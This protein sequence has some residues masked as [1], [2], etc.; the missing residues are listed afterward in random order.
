M[1]TLLIVEPLCDGHRMGYVRWIAKAACGSGFQT[2]FATLDASKNHPLFQVMLE[3]CKSQLRIVTLAEDVRHTDRRTDI[4][5][6]ARRELHFYRLFGRLFR[7]SAGIQEPDV[8][9]VPYI[10]HC[11]QAMAL[12]GSPFN[13]TP[14][15]GI[16]LRPFSHFSRMGLHGP[17][18][19]MILK[20][21]EKT[22]L[23]LMT[24]RNLRTLFTI[25][26]VFNE[27]MLAHHPA[28]AR[29]LQLL[30]DPAE[31]VGAT[32]KEGA[33]QAFGIPQDAFLILLYGSISSRKGLDKLLLSFRDRAIPSKV[34]VL[35]AGKQDES[36]AALLQEPIAQELTEQGR[37]HLKNHF[38]DAQEEYAAF[39]ASD[40]V[41]LGYRDHY[42]MSGVLVQAGQMNRPVIACKEGLIGWLTKKYELGIVVTMSDQSQII[43]AIKR[44]ARQ[45]DDLRKL[46]QRGQSVFGKHTPEN[47]G[48]TILEN[49]IGTKL[50]VR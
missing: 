43:E 23:R 24:N 36:A 40:A 25:D 26:E 6:L 19:S 8:V 4:L 10:D 14:W 2:T 17:P 3:E 22:F 31:L 1:R 13:E 15:A 20:I 47:F 21:K 29:K 5:G 44:L 50:S 48:E 38:L 27:F 35:L 11:A 34:H 46:G 9:L 32:S 41:W 33:R 37:L 30:N 7:E 28:L 16:F 45:E 12:L 49:L 18:P 42:T 39:Q